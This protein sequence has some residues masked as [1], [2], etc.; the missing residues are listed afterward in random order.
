[1]T[2]HKNRPRPL[3]PHLTVYKAEY[4]SMLSIY[5]RVT[6]CLL[7]L[8]LLLLG[9]IYKLQAYNIEYFLIL[10]NTSKRGLNTVLE[11]IGLTSGS[12]NFLAII[13]NT[14]LIFIVFA[15]VFMLAYHMSN[16]IRHFIWDYILSTVSKE[17]IKTTS[18]MV[19][20]LAAVLFIGLLTPIYFFPIT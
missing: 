14:V 8:C 11:N 12:I 2:D 18:Y 16:G 5:H 15:I 10:V 19:I 3:S 6:G 9:L 20:L 4:S 13:V 1:M 7:A 17:H